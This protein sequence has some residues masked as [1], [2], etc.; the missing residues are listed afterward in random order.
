MSRPLRIEVGEKYNQLTILE[1]LGYEARPTGRRI[2]MV[3]C[4]CDCGV[5]K[6]IAAPDVRSGT[7]KT[8]GTP[9]NHPYATRPR[10]TIPEFTEGEVF[11]KLKVIRSVGY[12]TTPSGARVP[13]VECE[14]ECGNKKI[15]SFWDLRSGKTKT[16]GVSHPF[17]DDRSAPAFNNYYA[18][19]YKSSAARR[20]LNFN[21]T[22][23]EF[24]ALTVQDCFYCGCPPSKE[25][26]CSTG[27]LVSTYI[28][29]GIDR[30]DNSLGYTMGNVVP[31]CFDCNHAKATLTQ[32]QF[33]E[34]ARKIAKMHPAQ[35]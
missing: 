22:K 12:D 8:C 18:S 31:C 4:Q 26:K 32:E 34:L 6:K 17:Y 25:I 28:A 19:T 30:V 13:K 7:T 35:N 24:R 9:G 16:C 21:L 1:F 29:N 2:P 3:S 33:L 15:V 27:T 20:G 14:C 5:V 23:E 10:R 11:G